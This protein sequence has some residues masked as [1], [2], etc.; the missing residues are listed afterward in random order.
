MCDLRHID[1]RFLSTHLALTSTELSAAL[2]ESVI[3]QNEKVPLDSL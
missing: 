1:V 3:A 2:H